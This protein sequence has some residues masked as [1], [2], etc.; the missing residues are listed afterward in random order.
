MADATLRS[1]DI[2][3]TLVARRCVEPRGIFR[4][5][6]A[7]A[8]HP[9]FAD[10]RMRAE[11]AI[12]NHGEYVLADIYQE[13]VASFGLS[14]A[15]ASRLMTLEMD[16]EFANLIPIRQH[17]AE[18]RPG[19]LLISDVYLPRRLVMRVVREKCGLHFNPVFLSSHGKSGGRAWEALAGAVRISEHTGDNAHA[20][21]AMC[22]RFGIRGRHTT[23]S[24]LTPGEALVAELGYRG[25]A[26]AMRAARLAFWSADPG[27]L[28][29]GRAQ[30]D[31]N[32]PLLFLTA[33]LLVDLSARKGWRHLLFSSRD[34]FLLSL[35]FE[36]I[37]GRLGLDIG[38]TYFFT[39]R[40]AR[41]APSASYLRYFG[42]LCSNAGTCVVDLCGTGWSLTRL[43]EVAG[44]SELDMFLM[45][46]MDNPQ[47]MR[48]DP[49]NR[50]YRARPGGRF[51][52]ARGQQCLA[53]G[54]ECDRPPDGDRCHR[55]R[56][57]VHP[58]ICRPGNRPA[59]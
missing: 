20:D 10:M 6:E 46:Y 51:C 57:C 50:G 22:E 33:L 7:T 56:P 36:R 14:T 5:V 38:S 40:V 21:I 28:M 55:G 43:F 12:Y 39:S 8:S 9:G 53:G 35:V 52:H 26:T 45:H 4:A 59:L 15:A 32:F 30:I 27:K 29:L 3:D 49:G 42:H 11:A 34:A 44:Q 58:G 54:P 24:Q 1:F 48:E 25:L 2:F 31:A 23:V 41:A 18:V 13:M 47:I 16:E 37:T 17:V 19:D